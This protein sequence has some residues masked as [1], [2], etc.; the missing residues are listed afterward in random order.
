MPAARGNAAPQT[1][2]GP[3]ESCEIAGYTGTTVLIPGPKLCCCWGGGFL[4][5]SALDVPHLGVC[6]LGN[7]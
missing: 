6:F 2:P 4:R 7:V 5:G 1:C 3:N